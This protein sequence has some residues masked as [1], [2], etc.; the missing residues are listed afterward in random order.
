[1]YIAI[2]QTAVTCHMWLERYTADK[3]IIVY[4]AFTVRA[5]LAMRPNV[6]LEC[7]SSLRYLVFIL[8]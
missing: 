8:H 4:Y 7:S 3:K 2:S 5:G 6:T 1:M